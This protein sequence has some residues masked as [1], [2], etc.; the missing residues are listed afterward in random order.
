MKVQRKK[1]LRLRS[2]SERQDSL[3]AKISLA[4]ERELRTLLEELRKR[5]EVVFRPDT[6]APGFERSTPAAGQCAAVATIVNALFGGNL[7][8]AVVQGHSHWFNQIQVGR[9]KVEIDLTGD[10]FGHPPLQVANPWSLYPATRTRDFS[11]LKKE[12]ISRAA[13]LAARAS[14]SEVEHSL[15]RALSQE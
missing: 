1:L 10:Q 4:D 6:A 8:S 11:E 2:G 13:V 5:L 3:S 15:R 14:L 9:A 7:V 12:T